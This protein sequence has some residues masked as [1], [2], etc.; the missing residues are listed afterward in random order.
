MVEEV[1]RF[2]FRE[3]NLRS[4][5]GVGEF[6]SRLPDLAPHFVTAGSGFGG[7]G[8]H[9]RSGV[10]FRKTFEGVVQLIVREAIA[11][12]GDDDEIAARLIK[13]I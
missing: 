6:R 2:P 12:G 9:G 11:F 3:K 1:E 10:D 7:E 8:D 4:E 13:K 5:N